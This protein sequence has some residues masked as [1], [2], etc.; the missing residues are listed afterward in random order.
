M[1]RVLMEPKNSFWWSQMPTK[2]PYPK[3]A[4]ASPLSHALLLED[5]KLHSPMPRSPKSY[6]PFG[7]IIYL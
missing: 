6:F 4:S 7:C 3:S 1:F 2:G 5:A